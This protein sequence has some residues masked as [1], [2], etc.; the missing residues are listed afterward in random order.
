MSRQYKEN[1]KRIQRELI[2]NYKENCDLGPPEGD[3]RSSYIVISVKGD[4]TYYGARNWEVEMASDVR[5]LSMFIHAFS[6][7]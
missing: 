4:M 3:V 7:S 5:P 1:T 2:Q 6:G